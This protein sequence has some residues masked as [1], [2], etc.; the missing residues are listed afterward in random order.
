MIYLDTHVIVWLYADKGKRLS[1]TARRLIEESQS[2]LISPMVMLE[3]DFLHEINRTSC[4][5]GPVFDY[6]KKWINLAI[7]DKSFSAVVLK[8]SDQPWTRDPFDRLIT[9]QA[10]L[11]EN[12]LI[13]KDVTIQKYY[14]NASW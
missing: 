8:A 5:S 4:G 13:T 3:L 7:C 2:L 14:P 12:L 11:D 10:A 9:A 1:T 6:L